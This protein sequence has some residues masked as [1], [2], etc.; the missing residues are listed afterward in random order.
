[1]CYKI[2]AID[3]STGR[4]TTSNRTCVTPTFPPPPSFSYIRKATVIA[5]NEISVVAYVDPAA[6][7]AG[8]SLHRST[9]QA[10][11]YAVVATLTITGTSTISFIDNVATEQGPYFYYVSTLDS[12]QTIVLNSQVVQTVYLTAA[13]NG[14][15]TN[16]VGWTGYT[17][18]PT[19]VGSYNLLLTIGGVTSVI[20][21]S[22]ALLPPYFYIDSVLD[23]F[24]SDGKF[25]YSVQ[26]IEE[27][28]NPY[29]YLDTVNSNEVC[30]EQPPMI[31]IP[32]AFHPGGGLNNIFFPSNAFVSTEG[33]SFDIYN[34]W[35]ENVFH[36]NDPLVGWPG[37]SNGVASPEGVYIYRLIAKNGKKADIEKV[38]SVTLIR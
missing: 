21:V 9:A 19:G 4:T 20:P 28:G 31:Y 15:Y 24:Y 38:G 35:G 13:A 16:L 36:T 12:C 2:R 5:E 7:V 25:C 6:S 8:Y 32:S 34:R 37:T 14:D 27:T 26:A 11:P 1:M 22:S 17:G 33:Y 10:G 30:V 18:W 23:N 3:L 29:F